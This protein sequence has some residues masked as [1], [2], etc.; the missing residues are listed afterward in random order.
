MYWKRAEKDFA[1]GPVA[2]TPN[3]G[4][5]GWIPGQATRS[6]MLQLRVPML[7]LKIP[8]T[9]TKKDSQCCNEDPACT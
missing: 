5:Q 6:H 4:C 1:G 9:V 8:Y 2:K 3:S 7:Q